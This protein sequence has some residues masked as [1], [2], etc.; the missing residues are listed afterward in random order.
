MQ[1]RRKVFPA[2]WP[3]L[4]MEFLHMAKVAEE[5]DR[6]QDMRELA[7]QAEFILS[8]THTGS[9]S[10]MLARELIHKSAIALTVQ[11]GVVHNQ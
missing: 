7:V 8:V 10:L 4:G 5:L 2:F 11:G 3:V 1:I 9:Q 6:P